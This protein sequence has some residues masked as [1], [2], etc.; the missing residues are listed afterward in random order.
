MSGLAASMFGPL[1]VAV[2]F[3]A[4]GIVRD[5]L[6][7]KGVNAVSVD[8]RETER[9]GPHIQADVFEW[10]EAGWAGAI[11]H[12]TC[13]W[14]CGSGL[15]WNARV[16]GRNLMTEWSLHQVR[17]LMASPIERW[18]IENPRGV[19]GSN[20]RPAD[21]VIQP[22]QFGD[23]ASKETHLWLR[24]LPPLEIRQEWRCHGRIV[25]DPNTGKMV[26][27]WANQTDAG[28]N[29]LGPS[30]DR[31][32]ERSQTYAGIAEAMARDWAHLFAEPV[33]LN[34]FGEAA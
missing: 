26:E 9:P 1:P 13:T 18:A 16:P 21:Q 30:E 10:L 28:Q 5:A 27:R 2:F 4:S 11:M 17:R 23:D 8:I 20:I 22:W 25:R 7:G 6:I 12:P 3:E 14:M 34:L 31:W 29:K 15:H 19:I 24:N 32:A 33:P